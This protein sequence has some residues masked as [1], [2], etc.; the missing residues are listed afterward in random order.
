VK[1]VNMDS[2][3]RWR[4]RRSSPMGERQP[5]P[6]FVY[7]ER[8]VSE[9]IAHEPLEQASAFSTTRSGRSNAMIGTVEPSNRIRM[10]TGNPVEL[11]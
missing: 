1:L 8:A 9:L 3:R 2:P 6:R 11:S 5:K 4:T 10:Q 7:L